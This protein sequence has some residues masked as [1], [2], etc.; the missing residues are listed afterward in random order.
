MVRC[1]WPAP[2]S[3]TRRTSSG[4]SASSLVGE[5]GAHERRGAARV[6]VR[7]RSAVV[8]DHGAHEAVERRVC[9]DQVLEL[10]E[11]HDRQPTA[12]LVE[13]AGKI[14]QLEQDLARPLR[15]AGGW[16]A[17]DAEREAGDAQ[18]EAK[19]RQEP[20]E[21]PA[22]IAGQVS[23]GA[24]GPR[25]HIPGGG[26]LAQI[27]EHCAMANGSHSRDVGGEQTRLPVAPRRSQPDRHSV[28][29]G[30]LEAVELVA[31][32]DEDRRV[33]GTLIVEGIHPCMSS[34]YRMVPCT[35]P[36]TLGLALEHSEPPRVIFRPAG[37][38]A[39]GRPPPP[40]RAR[41]P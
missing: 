24:C 11:T 14:E 34:T 41:R 1:G 10:I 31:T 15:L 29:G 32:V 39:L 12:G 33:D 22:R 5:E 20:V 4:S 36:R 6:H 35:R 27:D 26:D 28:G 37:A 3:T 9:G 2:R 38:S 40:R 19:P 21:A 16:P 7:G 13:H 18:A 17:R 25:G 30:A 23:E 8:L